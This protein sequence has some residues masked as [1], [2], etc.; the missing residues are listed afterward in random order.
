MSRS[1]V[2]IREVS[3][4]SGVSI[5]TVSRVVNH[6]GNVR[7][8][9]KQRVL[10]AI[11]ALSYHTDSLASSLKSGNSRTI[12]VVVPRFENDYFMRALKAID[13]VV[14]EAGYSLMLAATNNDSA[15]ERQAVSNMLS[16][17]T[18]GMIVASSLTDA[19]FFDTINAEHCPI[20]LIDRVIK[21]AHVDTIAEE[22]AAPAY[23][24]TQRLL[25]AGHRKIAAF[26]GDMNLGLMKDRLKGAR[27]AMRDHGLSFPE[28]F[29]VNC[30]NTLESGRQMAAS[31]LT[32]WQ[33]ENCLPT[34]IVALNSFVAEGIMLAAKEVGLHIPRDLSLV[35]FGLLQSPLIVPQ[36]TAVAQDGYKIGRLAGERLFQRLRQPSGQ[37]AE[38]EPCVIMIDSTIRLGDS[39][40]LLN[41]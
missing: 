15:R 24:I 21:G 17:K 3:E 19:S 10:K 13:E 22:N 20:V 9:T 6:L 33:A 1:R 34:A 8:D 18:A 37:G 26:T 5:A 28:S 30:K 39:I 29:V 11:E 23:A 7:P 2:T 32:A 36:I 31:A 40:R 27:Q 4:L 41:Q 25:A 12:G 16:F 14:S 38:M 35:S